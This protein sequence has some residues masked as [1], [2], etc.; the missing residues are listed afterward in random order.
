MASIGDDS[1]AGRGPV[2]GGRRE[3]RTGPAGCQGGRH[4]LCMDQAASR[5][6][7]LSPTREKGGAGI[8]CPALFRR[9]QFSI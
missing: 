5:M 2:T 3:E 6:Q 4:A 8:V 1:A 7:E 9:F